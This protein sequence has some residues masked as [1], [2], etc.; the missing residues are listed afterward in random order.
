MRP[1]NGPRQ[2][3]EDVGSYGFWPLDGGR[4]TNNRMTALAVRERVSLVN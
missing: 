1:K 3:A 2:G 4:Q